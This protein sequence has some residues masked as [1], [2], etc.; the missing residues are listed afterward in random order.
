MTCDLFGG[1]PETCGAMTSGGTESILVAIRVSFFGCELDLR[2]DQGQERITPFVSSHRAH[3]RTASGLAMKRASLSPTL[4]LP[5]LPTPHLTR[6][7]QS[8]YCDFGD[9]SP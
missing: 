5:A 9:P 3:R 6:C 8:M 4:W 1:G 2:A 7:A